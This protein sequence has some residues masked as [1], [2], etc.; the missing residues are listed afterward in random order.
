MR[1]HSSFGPCGGGTV[2]SS[3]MD[4][5]YVY[6]FSLSI[7]RTEFIPYDF[8]DLSMIRRNDNSRLSYVFFFFL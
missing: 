3:T 6:H 4:E 8:I 2:S 1:R 5:S 7:D